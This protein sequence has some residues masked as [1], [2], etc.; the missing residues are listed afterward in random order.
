MAFIA[1]SVLIT[2]LS[3]VWC[4]MEIDLSS[5]LTETYAGVCDRQGFDY[6]GYRTNTTNGG[7]NGLT[8]DGNNFLYY[9]TSSDYKIIQ[10]DTHSGESRLIA[11]LDSSP[12][13]MAHDALNG[14][15]MVIMGKGLMKIERPEYPETAKLVRV[16]D[17]NGML[18]NSTQTSGMKE[19]GA[20]VQLDC[21]TWIVSDIG[22]NRCV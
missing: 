14:Y 12:N 5:S 19:P 18:E 1:S 8:F 4:L 22:S 11:T 15:L 6:H 7:P 3:E 10:I 13:A 17:S 2:A 21:S 9:S 20:L 16:I